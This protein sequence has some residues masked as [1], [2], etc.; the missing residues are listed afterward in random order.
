MKVVEI[1]KNC[2][3]LV[4]LFLMDQVVSIPQLIAMYTSPNPIILGL[5]LVMY[6]LTAGAV[7]FFLYQFYR[8]KI[9]VNHSRFGNYRLDGKRFRFML[10]I[11]V[12]WITFMFL[13]V[14]YTNLFDIGTSRNQSAIEQLFNQTPLW[15]FVDGVV[16]APIMEELIFRG[17][18]FEFFFKGDRPAVKVVGILINGAVFGALHDTGLS[19]PIYAMMG[20]LLAWTYVHTKDLKY[21][22]SIHIL[23]NLISFI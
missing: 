3:W 12:L 10:L 1:L 7:I 22:M 19:F 14:W 15:T 9:K 23:N 6:G 8:H 11:V 21:S 17:L 16:I 20:C 5:L 18:F 4:L 13:Q 2:L